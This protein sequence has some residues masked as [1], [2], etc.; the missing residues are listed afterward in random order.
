MP[1]FRCCWVVMLHLQ[2]WPSLLTVLAPAASGRCGEVAEVSRRGHAM[3]APCI[4]SGLCRV[5]YF[6]GWM[7]VSIA[8]SVTVPCAG[9]AR[10]S[11]APGVNTLTVV[12]EHRRLPSS[13]C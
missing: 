13:G 6:L 5:A 4:S 11:T 12:L 2:D 9:A 7:L 8:T 10:A 3:T 1:I